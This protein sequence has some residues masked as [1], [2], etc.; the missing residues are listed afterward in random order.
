MIGDTFSRG[1]EKL[2]STYPMV[3]L[4]YSGPW[5]PYNFVH[6]RIGKDGIEFK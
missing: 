2:R 3:R 6:I 5:A 4:L 1:V